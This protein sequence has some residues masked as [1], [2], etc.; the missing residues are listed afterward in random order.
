MMPRLLKD[1]DYSLVTKHRWMWPLV[2][3]GAVFLYTARD[4]C[5]RHEQRKTD[6]NR[7]AVTKW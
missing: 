2:D 3:L 6:R 4:L 1:A 5:M 7:R